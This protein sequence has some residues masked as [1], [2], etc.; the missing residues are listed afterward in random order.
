MK[1]DTPYFVLREGAT[2]EE[3]WTWDDLE[4]L[5]ESG[6][7]TPGARVF[8]PDK[9]EWV[10]A[11]ETDLRAVFARASSR[12]PGGDETAATR[13]ALQGDYQATLARLSE[14]P[15]AVDVLAEAGRLA[16]ELG[17]RDAARGH[18]QAALEAHPYH[19]RTAQE[20]RRRFARGEARTFRLIQRPNALWD[21][22][23]ELW[24]F[25]FARGPLYVALP[26]LVFTVLAFVPH[27]TIA[28]AVLA[29]AWGQQVMR[30]AAGG[31]SLPPLWHRAL[32]DPLREV[33]LPLFAWA[34]SCALLTALFFGIAR[35]L[36]FIDSSVADTALEYLLRS[37]VLT[38]MAVLA[39]V[40][41]LPAA[42]VTAA[43][44]QPLAALDPVR[45]VRAALRMEMEY[46][47]SVLFLLVLA[48][49]G[50]MLWV[51]TKGI[52]VAGNV[53]LGATVAVLV[54]MGGLVLGRLLGRTAHVFVRRQD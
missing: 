26:A 34:G 16:F 31:A 54:P 12:T 49:V 3:Q 30:E 17:D 23:G 9:N 22:L 19:P 11:E 52:P 53:L 43:A 45:V 41:Y 42:A 18:F 6:A 27:G 21:D 46:I 14:R 48:F 36:M 38:V 37:P 33:V 47:L 40:G 20:V 50:G 5:C 25:P 44:R 28:I 24:R 39:A 35:G 29:F 4:S 13:E 15:D 1:T 32:A 10:C 8:L 51:A 7:L 2:Q